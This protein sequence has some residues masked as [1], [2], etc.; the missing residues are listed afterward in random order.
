MN[1][2]AQTQIE[3]QKNAVYSDLHII[4]DDLDFDGLE[5]GKMILD[6]D[7]IAQDI[8]HAIRESGVLEKLIAE[9]SSSFIE[10]LLDDLRS[11]I[12]TDNRVIPGSVRIDFI[13]SDLHLAADTDFGP[14]KRSLA[15]SGVSL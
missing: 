7:C 8:I 11:V 2:K 14:I 10:F 9:R 1:T 12:E 13:E 4:D 15:I 5:S 6:S 3:A